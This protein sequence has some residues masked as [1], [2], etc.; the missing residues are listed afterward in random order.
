M[1]VA[2]PSSR[3]ARARELERLPSPASVIHSH[4]NSS[5][6]YLSASATATLTPRLSAASL[7]PN[8]KPNSTLPA[9]PNGPPSPQHPG[10]DRAIRAASSGTSSSVQPIGFPQTLAQIARTW[11]PRRQQSTLSGLRFRDPRLSRAVPPPSRADRVGSCSRCGQLRAIRVRSSWLSCRQFPRSATGP[12]PVNS[13][14]SDARA[15]PKAAIA[16]RPPR[17]ARPTIL[18]TGSGAHES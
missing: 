6:I 17:T 12:Q 13:P 18:L 8:L 15:L 2:I 1:N 16:R 4:Q 7:Q 5:A 10:Q 11:T 3:A 9:S 14:S